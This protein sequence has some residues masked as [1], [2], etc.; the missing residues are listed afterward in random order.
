MMSK[1]IKFIDTIA[2]LPFPFDRWITHQTASVLS[3]PR[4]KYSRYCIHGIQ[5]L[6][7]NITQNECQ[8]IFKKSQHH[9]LESMLNFSKPSHKSMYKILNKT[10]IKGYE[11]IQILAKSNKPIVAVSIHMSDFF[12]GL[13]KLS[14]HLP[15]SRNIGLIKFGDNKKREL[16]T[17]R[18]MN[19]LDLNVTYF[20][21][22]NKPA[23]DV[24]RFLKNKGIMITFIDIIHSTI[25]TT[26]VQFFNRE[27]NFPCGPAELA[28]ASNSIIVPLYTFKTENG[29]YSLNIEDPIDI[30]SLP[31]TSFKENTTWITQQ[32]ATYIQ[33][34]IE[35]HPDQWEFWWLGN[36]LWTKK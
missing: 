36:E 35:R 14:Q 8:K 26:K 11:K 17:S 7:P 33:S 1:I 29:T 3:S 16:F 31:G 20:N 27:A 9:L 30:H 34:W 24:L 22:P 15:K 6:F 12:H 23:F 19:S 21:L 25:K 32:L 2:Y 28:I 10:H 18:K 4:F 5:T 13:L